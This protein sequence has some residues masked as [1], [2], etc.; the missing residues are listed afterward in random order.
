LSSLFL[1]NLSIITATLTNTTHPV[2]MKM[3]WAWIVLK[4]SEHLSRLYRL[5]GE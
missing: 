1:K 5:V 3:A 4:Y 2:N